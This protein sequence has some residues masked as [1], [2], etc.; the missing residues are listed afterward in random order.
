MRRQFDGDRGKRQSQNQE[1]HSH[2][3]LINRPEG[4]DEYSNALLN[5]SYTDRNIINEE[6]HGVTC[7]A[8]TESPELLDTALYSLKIEL[9]QIEE[10]KAYN[11]A[12]EMYLSGDGNIGHCAYVDSNEF[13][14]RFLR[15]EL[16]DAKK[17]AARMIKYLNLVHENF[18][19]KALTRF[20]RL[21]DLTKEE[22]S[23]M[24]E[25]G[26]QLLPY[27]DRGGRRILC[28]VTNNTNNNGIPSKTRLKVLMYLWVVASEDI[29]TQRKGL[30][31]L[32]LSGPKITDGDCNP[33]QQSIHSRVIAHTKVAYAVPMRVA[34]IHLCFHSDSSF[35]HSILKVYS[36]AIGMLSTRVKMHLGQPIKIRYQL[37]SYG[38]PVEMIPATD[39][40]N[41]KHANLKHWIKVRRILEKFPISTRRGSMSSNSSDDTEMDFEYTSNIIQHGYLPQ[42]QQRTQQYQQIQYSNLQI[43]QQQQSNQQ[44]QQQQHPLIVECPGSTDVIFRRGKSMAYHPGNNMFQG[45]IESRLEEHTEANQAEKMAIVLSLIQQIEKEKGGRFLT[46]DSKNNLWL[47]MMTIPMS[48]THNSPGGL[49]TAQ[50]LEIQ[51]KVSYAFRDCR[52]K[53]AS[54]ERLQV[55]RSSTYAFERQDGAQKKRIKSGRESPSFIERNFCSD[56]E[57]A[58][59]S[60]GSI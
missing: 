2:S 54:R 17:A 40:G 34:A 60:D 36:A 57:S 8:P 20:L 26:Y 58:G 27:R 45:L 43:Q 6:I 14:L 23:F 28:I 53:L 3:P 31:I 37:K 47:D 18:G 48:G 10:K 56:N 59:F 5:L 16:F 29:E 9:S 13:Q 41:V 22:M 24:R 49:F 42:Q 21:S 52:K 35:F 12:Q 38:I 50:E 46:W 33:E 11:V 4:Y 25:G 44:Q 1:E 51:S 32:N 15:C 30:I 7:M 19:P 39:T 55:S